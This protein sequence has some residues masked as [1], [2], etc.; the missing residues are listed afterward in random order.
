MLNAVSRSW[1]I[2]TVRW[3]PPTQGL[4]CQGSASTR[5]FQGSLGHQHPAD[6]QEEG[7]RAVHGSFSPRPGSGAVCP[8][9]GAA[10]REAVHLS[11]PG[12]QVVHR[13]PLAALQPP[14][15][16]PPAP[17]R[18]WP[19]VPSRRS[20]D[21]SPESPMMPRLPSGLDCGS[22]WSRKLNSCSRPKQ[23]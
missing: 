3:A 11:Y 15:T 12:A 4:G 1:P 7:T 16:R 23:C 20:A 19:C 10:C 6:L 8:W 21:P 9:L 14:L 5:G 17:A 13:C 22:L 2:P 18:R